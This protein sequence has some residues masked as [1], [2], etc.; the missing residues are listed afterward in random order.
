MGLGAI[1]EPTTARTNTNTVNLIHIGME[2]SIDIPK[3]S[4]YKVSNYA[5]DIPPWYYINK[6]EQRIEFTPNIPD[7]AKKTIESNGKLTFDSEMKTFSESI[8]RSGPTALPTTK[9]TPDLRPVEA[10]PLKDTFQ[11]PSA[12]VVQNNSPVLELNNNKLDLPPRKRR[13]FSLGEAS[14]RAKVSKSTDEETVLRKID[15]GK[16]KKKKRIETIESITL[17]PKIVVHNYGELK[18]S[19]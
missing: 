12:K 3:S 5:I 10:L 4:D 2:H 13:E 17:K 18:I 8:R 6:D 11:P 7:R 15:G 14:V 9:L 16:V 19:K 1:G